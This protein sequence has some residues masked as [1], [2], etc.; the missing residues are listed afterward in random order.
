MVVTAMWSELM[1]KEISL[2]FFC[3]NTCTPEQPGILSNTVQPVP[4]C[5]QRRYRNS[6]T[7]GPHAQ[8]LLLFIVVAMLTEKPHYPCNASSRYSQLFFCVTHSIPEFHCSFSC[9][10][11]K[12]YHNHQIKDS[13]FLDGSLFL[14][15]I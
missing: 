9:Y 8:N 11:S 1:P 3:K 10:S 15:L 4:K 14:S 2:S 6:P 12:I 5:I 7:P 13:I